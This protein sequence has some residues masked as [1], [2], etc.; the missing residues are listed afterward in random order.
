MNLLKFNFDLSALFPEGIIIAI[1]GYI[2][3]FMA[4]VVL[5]VV[6]TYLSKTLNYRARLKLRREGRYKA[7]EEKQLFISGDVAAAIS[8]AIYLHCELHDEESNVITIKRVSKT[9]SPWSSKIYAI[10]DF[11]GKN[12]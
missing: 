8:M 7:A 10:R 5:Y 11:P 12:K 1:V 3:V 9:Y 6:F 4:L 2:T